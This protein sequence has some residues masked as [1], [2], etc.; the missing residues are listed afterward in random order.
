MR[1]I[2]C[3]Q[4]TA[5]WFAA[6]AGAIT[7]SNFAE[8][9]KRLKSGP[10]KGDFTNA[11]HK[12]AFRV[13]I[14]RISGE[15]LDVDQYDTWA[16][17]R[18]RELEPEARLA[19]EAAKGILVEQAGIAL[20]D[21]GVFGASV[22]GLIDHDGASEYKCFISPDSLMPILLNDDLSHVIDQVQG[23][24]WVTE[25]LWADFV[26]YCPALKNIGRDLTIIRVERDDNFIEQLESDLLEFNK[27]VCTYEQKLRG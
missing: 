13:A 7:A 24:L 16:M 10:N 1:I 23:Q 22:D 15:L 18:G 5:E 19:H 26:L 12:Y 14:E 6:R 9:R 2:E 4:G 11:A 8:C 17:K 25:R 21:D 27:L 3:E 20:T